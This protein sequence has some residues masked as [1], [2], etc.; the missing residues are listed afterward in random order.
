VRKLIKRFLGRDD[1]GEV[2]LSFVD[3][4]R[5]VT[6]PGDNRYDEGRAVTDAYSAGMRELRGPPAATASAGAG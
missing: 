6:H 3:R 5:Q 4:D 1:E 2:D